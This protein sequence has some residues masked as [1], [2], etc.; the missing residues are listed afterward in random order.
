MTSTV[1]SA[2]ERAVTTDASITVPLSVKPTSR[3]SARTIGKTQRS[4]VMAN[5]AERTPE[6]R[7]TLLIA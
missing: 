2:A 6:V 4:P 1:E 5:E 3:I 7:L